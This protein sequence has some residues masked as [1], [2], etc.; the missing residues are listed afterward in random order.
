[1][2]SYHLGVVAASASVST[3][4][5]NGTFLRGRVCQLKYFSGGTLEHS[6][7]GL[8]QRIIF[9]TSSIGLSIGQ[10]VFFRTRRV[11]HDVE[12][13][14]ICMVKHCHQFNQMVGSIGR[15]DQKLA[16]LALAEESIRDVAKALPEQ[17]QVRRFPRR[18]TFFQN[19]TQEEQKQLVMEAEKL[20][21]TL[22]SQSK[23][24]GDAI[25]RL[26]RKCASWLHPPLHTSDSVKQIDKARATDEV[27]HMQFQWR[28]RRILIKALN[29]LDL[30]DPYTFQAVK[31]AMI[32]LASL[33]QPFNKKSEIISHSSTPTQKQ[34]Q[35]LRSFFDGLEHL[36]SDQKPLKD[37]SALHTSEQGP[38]N[39]ASQAGMF[40][41]FAGQC[42]EPTEKVKA[43]ATTFHDTKATLK[44]SDCPYTI[45]SN[46]RFQ[47]P[48][49]LK[50]AILGPKKGHSLCQR[51]LKRWCSWKSLDGSRVIKCIESSLSYCRHKRMLRKCIACGSPEICA[52]GKWMYQCKECKPCKQ[53]LGR[54]VRPRPASMKSK[55]LFQ[56]LRHMP[57]LF[58]KWQMMACFLTEL[59]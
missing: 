31:T 19:A 58:A 55:D 2:S 15:N 32:F 34:W 59:P 57:C 35:K 50:C 36:L 18:R 22:L 33:T 23:L 4:E 47:N 5:T 42:F 53:N 12:A 29:N 6:V 26:V 24:D 25:C 28:V 10:E 45:T 41:G 40:Y 17:S 11:A 21:N 30:Q 51:K 54:N 39:Q 3:M 56:S 9:S 46:W 38:Q 8:V 49:T 27:C 48:K 43:L 16:P 20:L 44:C 1:M 52:H 7:H 37:Q 14:G 13:V